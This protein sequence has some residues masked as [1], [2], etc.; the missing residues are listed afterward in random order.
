MSGA[1]PQ[2]VEPMRLD[3]GF[4]LSN[5]PVSSHDPSQLQPAVSGD[6]RGPVRPGV[7]EFERLDDTLPAAGL[8]QQTQGA[9]LGGGQRTPGAGCANGGAVGPDGGRRS[10]K[11]PN[12]NQAV[13]PGAYLWWYVDAISDDGQYALSIIAFVGSVFSPYYARAFAKHG[14]AVDAQNHCAINVAL[15][16]PG[17]RWAMTERGT[18][19]VARSNDQLV[20]GPSQ[21]KWTGDHLQIDLNEVSVPI[22]KRV[23]GTVRVYPDALCN[24]SNA[25]DDQGKHRWGPIA[26][27][28]RVEVDLQ[29]PGLKWQGHAYLDS[30]DGDEPVTIPFKTWDWSRARMADGSTAVIYDVTQTSGALTLLAERFKPDGSWESFTPAKKREQLPPTLWRID[31]GV[32]ADATAPSRVIDTLEDTPFYAR[33]LLQTSL[34]GEQVT[35]VHETLQP[36]R[37]NHLPVRLMLPW[38][39]PRRA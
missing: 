20:I 12:F 25:L 33:S 35:A 9:L 16:G 39:M 17:S 36:Q 22:P 26:P 10:H 38:R 3:S 2:T 6:G 7:Y 28:A 37:L 21:L 32:R 4:K 29:K 13:G 30:N 8:G 1:K 15:Y 27:C 11:F 24:Y 5:S 31:R 19:S 34:L 14:A 23:L 18:G